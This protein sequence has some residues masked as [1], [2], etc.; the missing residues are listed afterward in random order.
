M[1][2]SS[3]VLSEALAAGVPVIAAKISGLM[4]TLGKSFLGYYPVGDTGKLRRLLLRAESDREF[5][6]A[7]KRQCQSLAPIVK[8]QRELAAWRDLIKEIS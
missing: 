8:P 1:E 3:N 5:Y 4:G 2:G 6:R 7:L